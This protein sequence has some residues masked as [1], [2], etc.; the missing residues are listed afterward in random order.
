M[1]YVINLFFFSGS[2]IELLKIINQA[3]IVV[4]DT[5][6]LKL[7]RVGTID[8]TPSQ[9]YIVIFL[10]NSVT[11]LVTQIVCQNASVF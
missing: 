3:N 1:M 8:L 9:P 11:K 2:P 4:I 7:P 10:E 5:A 6:V